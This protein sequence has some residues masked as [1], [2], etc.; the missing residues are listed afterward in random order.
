M[1]F[2]HSR[3]SS[4]VEVVFCLS[5]ELVRSV[6]TFSLLI[7][8]AVAAFPLSKLLLIPFSGVGG[9]DGGVDGVEASVLFLLRLARNELEGA[10]SVLI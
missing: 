1:P 4:V 3:S 10:I 8:V 9:D 2:V 5:R 7:I 6:N